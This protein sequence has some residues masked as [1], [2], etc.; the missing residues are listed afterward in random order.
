MGATNFNGMPPMRPNMGRYTEYF[1]SHTKPLKVVVRQSIST[2]AHY[3]SLVAF[4]GAQ[5][6]FRLYLKWSILL[7]QSS[8]NYFL[9][10][11]C[12]FKWQLQIYI[13]ISPFE[14]SLLNILFID[15]ICGRKGRWFFDI[16]I[17]K[18]KKVSKYFGGVVHLPRK[19]SQPIQAVQST[20]FRVFSQLFPYG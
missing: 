19:K 8:I 17:I 13:N 7:D 12:V 4:Y 14:H 3:F 18:S 1:Q 6:N 10:L 20:I 16:P 11:N 2:A 9:F 15:F 5:K